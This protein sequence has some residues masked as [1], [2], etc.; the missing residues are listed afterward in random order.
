M[1]EGGGA[2]GRE[3]LPVDLDCSLQK[4]QA[5]SPPPLPLPRCLRISIVFIKSQF[6]LAPP[7]SSASPLA[8]TLPLALMPHGSSGGMRAGGR[9]RI[10]LYWQ[11]LL[12]AMGHCTANGN[13][14][15][16]CNGNGCQGSRG[17]CCC[18]CF[19]FGAD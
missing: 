7:T 13:G 9:G 1:T 19:C 3:Y 14:K 8:S 17:F 10:I 11:M 15:C 2:D 12:L 16:Y 5:V 18:F 6:L 4:Q